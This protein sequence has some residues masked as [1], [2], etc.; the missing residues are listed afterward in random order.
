M[1]QVCDKQSN[2]VYG[3]LVT[4]FTNFRALL[5]V[6]NSL[7]WSRRLE[8]AR[9]CCFL[10]LRLTTV[11]LDIAS[12]SKL[13]VLEV[14][15]SIKF[16]RVS[17]VFETKISSNVIVAPVFAIFINKVMSLAAVLYYVFHWQSA[18]IAPLHVFILFVTLNLIVL[19][20]VHLTMGYDYVQVVRSTKING[21][22]SC[23]HTTIA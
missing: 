6:N 4:A 20:W 7:Q 5:R 16:P 23:R 14:L 9:V 11:S 19:L 21:P 1:Y 15:P 10:A 12:Y 22:S 18:L 17:V 13:S 8:D 3:S 2:S